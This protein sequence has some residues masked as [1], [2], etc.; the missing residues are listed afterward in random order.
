[1]RG[2]GKLCDALRDIIAKLYVLRESCTGKI[3]TESSTENLTWFQGS[4][5]LLKEAVES[6]Q[7]VHFDLAKVTSMVEKEGKDW[8]DVERLIK[9]LDNSA[10]SDSLYS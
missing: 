6:L 9:K 4:E 7:K 3:E 10:L 1:M 5:A 2:H 8:A